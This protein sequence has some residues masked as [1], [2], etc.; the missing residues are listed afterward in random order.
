MHG[1]EPGTCNLVLSPGKDTWRRPQIEKKLRP[2]PHAAGRV[3]ECRGPR[4]LSDLACP[5]VRRRVLVHL[6]HSTSAYYRIHP[7]PS[8]CL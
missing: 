1:Q 6:L 3:G 4:L 7:R 2:Y 8:A 5:K